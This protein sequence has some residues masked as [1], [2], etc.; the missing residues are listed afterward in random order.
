TPLV[1]LCRG[2]GTV[3]PVLSVLHIGCRAPSLTRAHPWRRSQRSGSVLCGKGARYRCFEALHRRPRGRGYACLN[4]ADADSHPPVRA[5][6][7]RLDGRRS[8]EHTSE[9]QSPYDLVCRLLLEKKKKTQT[10]CDKKK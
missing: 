4:G 2:I 9:L 10:R 6:R 1:V 5:G 7:E 8:E 3:L